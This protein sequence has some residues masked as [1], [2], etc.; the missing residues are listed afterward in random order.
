MAALTTAGVTVLKA[1]NL[2]ALGSP[3]LTMK[4][5]TLVLSTAG[6]AST[7]T[8]DATTIGFT[9]IVG[10]T[11]AIK[12]DDAIIVPAVPSYDGSKILLA[13]LAQATDA[14]RDDPAT[15]SGTFR[16]TVT[17]YTN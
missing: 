10:C 14:N 11:N 1:T 7:D 9:S 5:L 13:N 4:R 16:V 15:F 2:V 3:R 12:S 6:T 17:G 8:I